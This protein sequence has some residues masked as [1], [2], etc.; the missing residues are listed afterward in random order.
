MKEET[1]KQETDSKCWSHIGNSRDSSDSD[2]LIVFDWDNT[3]FPT[4]AMQRI[5]SERQ[6]LSASDLA[7]LKALSEVVYSVLFAYISH[8]SSRNVC[9]V[10]AARKGWIESCLQSMV[11]VG[12]WTAIRNLL[13]DRAHPIRMVYPPNSALPFATSKSVLAYK[14]G[15]FRALVLAQ[16]PRLLVSIGD[17]EAEYVA[18]HLSAKGVQGMAV[19]RVLLK[20]HPSIE[21]MIAQ[22]HFALNLCVNIRNTNFDYDLRTAKK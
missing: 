5:Y 9:I 22:N 14:Y 16:R 21:T 20:R 7:E 10:T 15:A 2:T 6:S 11:G 13:F 4:K 19:G 1:M 12:S 3:L 18:S 17:S 8:Y